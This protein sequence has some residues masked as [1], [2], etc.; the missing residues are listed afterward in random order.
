[1]SLVVALNGA[2]AAPTGAV[3]IRNVQFYVPPRP[4]ISLRQSG[5]NVVVAWPISAE[6]WKLETS[7]DLVNWTEQSS[8]PDDTTSEHTMTF[9][10][11]N[12]SKYFFRLKK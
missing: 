1:V 8:P 4:E 2:T 7:T 9:D 12:A 5:S 10:V 11:A 6:G 3:S